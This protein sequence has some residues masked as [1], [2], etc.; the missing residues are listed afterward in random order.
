[1]ILFYISA[2][3]PNFQHVYVMNRRT[4][5]VQCDFTFNHLQFSKNCSSIFRLKNHLIVVR[6][7]IKYFIKY[8]EISLLLIFYC[9]YV[10]SKIRLIFKANG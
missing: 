2:V 8:L 4:G 9:Y 1:M 6:R 5:Q 10:S 3:I 7:R